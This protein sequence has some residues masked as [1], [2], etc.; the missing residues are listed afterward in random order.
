MGGEPG[1]HRSGPRSPPDPS[2]CTRFLAI[3][4]RWCGRPMYRW[5]P[6]C[7]RTCLIAW[8]PPGWPPSGGPMLAA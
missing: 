4:T 6:A 2:S 5:P 3:T 8:P 1:R 7:C